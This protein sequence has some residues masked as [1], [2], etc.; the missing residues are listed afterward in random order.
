MRRAQG[1][2]YTTVG[3]T[4]GST[5]KPT[6]EE[7]CSDRT[8]HAEAVEVTFDSALTDYETLARLFFEIH[9]PTQVDRQGPDVGKQ[10]RSAVFYLDEEQ[11]K[12][13][14]KLIGI[15]RDKGL[16]VATE[17]T[18]AGRFWPAE[19]Y[20]QDYYEKTG[21]LPYCHSRVKRF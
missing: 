9:D 16:D 2:L 20:H 10:Y 13:A 21:K 1:V 12:I 4:G 5:E 3:Y 7:V 6:Y 8:G 11:K 19:D 17:V 18:P 15:L 14:Q